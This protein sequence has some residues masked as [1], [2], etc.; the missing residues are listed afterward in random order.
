MAHHSSQLEPDGVNDASIVGDQLDAP[1]RSVGS[2]APAGLR[3]KK[4]CDFV[5]R[6]RS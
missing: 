3:Q 1:P 2:R 5:L 4:C 6:S